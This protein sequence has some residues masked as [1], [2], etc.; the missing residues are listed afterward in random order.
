MLGVDHRELGQEVKAVVVS[1]PG[2]SFD[3][4]VLRVHVAEKLAYYKVP[5][6]WERRLEP[7]P[8]NA[9]GKVLK[10]ELG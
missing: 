1:S 6:H 4:E 3:P 5:A 10:T 7:L 9:A 2:A 8:R